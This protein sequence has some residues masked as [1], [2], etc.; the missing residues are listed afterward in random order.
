MEPDAPLKSERCFP[1]CSVLPF[2]FPVPF[3]VL[4]FVFSFFSLR[5][6][7]FV[8]PVLFPFF[9]ILFL[10]VF[11]G[12]P[13]GGGA[14]FGGPGLLRGGVAPRLA[15]DLRA[16][17]I[18][19]R[20]GEPLPRGGSLRRAGKAGESGAGLKCFVGLVCVHLKF[21]DFNLPFLVCKGSYH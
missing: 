3:F 19:G 4:F 11:W 13:G 1:C 9:V 7:P 18:P 10:C 21:E 12:P 17:G 20:R 8:A 15:R 16:G 5:L 2:G 14:D 6:F